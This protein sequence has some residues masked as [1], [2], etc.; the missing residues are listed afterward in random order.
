M[1]TA[2]MAPVDQGPAEAGHPEGAVAGWKPVGTGTS[3][4]ASPDPD[5]SEVWLDAD[6]AHAPRPGAFRRP[7]IVHH[8]MYDPGRTVEHP[9]SE[10]LFPPVANG[11]DYLVSVVEHLESGTERPSARDLK[12]A[13]LHLAAG[14]EVL[15]KA[16]LQAEHWSLVFKDPGKAKHSELQDGSFV[17]CGPTEAIDRLV[18]IARIPIDDKDRK[19]VKELAERRNALQHYGLI[20]KAANSFAVESK[21][22]EVLNFLISFL[23]DHLLPTLSEAEQEEAEVDMERIRGGLLRIGGFV[24]KRLQI[25]GSALKPLQE[26]TVRCFECEQFTYVVDLPEGGNGGIPNC[27]FCRTSASPEDA[28][29]TYGAMLAGKD[30]WTPDMESR[31]SLECPDCLQT[32]LVC[33]VRLMSDPAALVDFCFQCAKVIQELP[34]ISTCGVCGREHWLTGRPACDSC[35]ELSEVGAP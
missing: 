25:L 14:A 15:L 7:G 3:R 19:A 13:A 20:G 35:L 23:D 27:R 34:P 31:A 10:A 6:G 8:R 30:P 2:D 29:L 33:G 16:R 21:T 22:A 32:A 28:A 17:S 18:D 26:R 5:N 1:T 24:K 9:G 4:G 11:L 12:Y